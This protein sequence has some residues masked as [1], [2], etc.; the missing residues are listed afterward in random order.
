MDVFPSILSI[1]LFLLKKWSYK[2]TGIYQVT[3]HMFY[4]LNV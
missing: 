2:E 4:D 3:S 1:N